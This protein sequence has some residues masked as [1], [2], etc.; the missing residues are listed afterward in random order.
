MPCNNHCPGPAMLNQK[1]MNNEVSNCSGA[2]QPHPITGTHLP[3]RP[4]PPIGC[5]PIVAIFHLSCGWRR[6]RPL[7]RRYMLTPCPFWSNDYRGLLV[8]VFRNRRQ[9]RRRPQDFFVW[10][11]EAFNYPKRY[12]AAM[13]ML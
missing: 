12:Y 10:A 6:S 13:L 2:S 8:I 4:L 9:R 11:R 7:Y 1:Q 3:R 5:F